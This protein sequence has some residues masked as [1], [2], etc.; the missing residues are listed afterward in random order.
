MVLFIVYL[1][2]ARIERPQKR[3][4]KGA[5]ES[6]GLAGY[7]FVTYETEEAAQA[8]VEKLDKLSESRLVSARNVWYFR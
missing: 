3:A 7:A 2:S 4:N 6:T 5:E 1:L 8:A